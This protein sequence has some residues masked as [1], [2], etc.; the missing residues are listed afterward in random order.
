MENSKLKNTEY[1]GISSTERELLA[2]LA[3]IEVFTPHD[4]VQILGCTR[5]Y[6]YQ[7]AGRLLR[8][9][10]TR[11]IGRGKYILLNLQGLE[12]TDLLSQA[13]NLT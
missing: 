9:H 6:S 4:I 13:S 12:K 8:K 7:I 11:R 3:D 1:D 5:N 2:N 10:I